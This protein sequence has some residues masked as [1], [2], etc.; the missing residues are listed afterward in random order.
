MVDYC[1]YFKN[2]VLAFP[3][4]SDLFCYIVIIWGFI[5]FYQLYT[6]KQNIHERILL[7]ENVC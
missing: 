3:C 6:Q 4:R 5:V 7:T 2:A 1:D